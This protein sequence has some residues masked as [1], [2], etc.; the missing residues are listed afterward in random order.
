MA[1]RPGTGGCMGGK[2]KRR[3]VERREIVEESEGA[4][5]R[6]GGAVRNVTVSWTRKAISE[7]T[8]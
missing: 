3:S 1:E 8:Q 5:W 6:A 7:K 4:T 2:D